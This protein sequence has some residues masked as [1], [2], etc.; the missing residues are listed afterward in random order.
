MEGAKAVK[1][2]SGL[3]VFFLVLVGQ[4]WAQG[5]RLE[6]QRL[7]V[8]AQQEWQ[9]WSLGDLQ[10]P[11][12]EIRQDVVEVGPEGRIS[13][14]LIQKRIDAVSGAPTFSHFIEGKT[15][16][17]YTDVFQTGNDLYA[18]GGIKGAG[19]NL[20]LAAW[21]IDRGEDRLRTFWEP[22]L[23]RPSSDWWL[24]IDLGRLVSAEKVIVRFVGEELGDP[25]LQFRVLVS[26]G[27]FAF[28]NR[29]TLEYR[30]IG[31]T[32][33]GIRDQRLFEFPLRPDARADPDTPGRPSSTCAWWSP[34][35]GR[36][37]RPG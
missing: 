5:F 10:Q 37:G 8:S 31:G 17:F 19:S 26:N 36:A 14:R 23:D 9:Q 27:D 29:Q 11:L 6:G 28:G 16:D 34:R 24:E 7:V 4:A 15:K 12:G 22:D 1:A 3:V 21:A 32:T 35:A 25:F 30:S 13:P 2:R 20:S 18:R 33:Q